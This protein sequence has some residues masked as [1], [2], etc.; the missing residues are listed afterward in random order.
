MEDARR[1]ICVDLDGTLVNTDLSI[2]AAKKFVR[3]NVFNVFRLVFWYFR[4][5]QYLKYRVADE[6]S[7]DIS[8][9]P[10]NFSFLSYL[11]HK[12]SEGYEIYLATG[13]SKKYA[14]QVARYL[15]VFDGVFASDQEVNLIGKNKA[16][17]LVEMFR[18]GGFDYAGNST[19]DVSVWMKAN[20]KILVNPDSRAQEAMKTIPHKLFDS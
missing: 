1:V 7:L 17:K 11:T 10:Y 16:D 13:A 5:I 18:E 2:D 12:K 15:E 4:G 8:N 3:K 20:E 6:V 9:L 14:E 19:D